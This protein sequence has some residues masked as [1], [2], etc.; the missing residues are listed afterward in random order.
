MAV[1]RKGKLLKKY[2]LY[3]HATGSLSNV[4]VDVAGNTN[5]VDHLLRKRIGGNG[6]F[7]QVEFEIGLRN[8]QSD[9]NFKP[10]K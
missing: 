6:N 4:D 10:I 5:N 3:R 7:S 8:Y 2:R 1:R 9:S